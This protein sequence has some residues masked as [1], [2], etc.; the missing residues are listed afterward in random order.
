MFLSRRIHQKYYTPNTSGKTNTK[1]VLMQNKR[2][3]GRGVFLAYP[4]FNA[5]FE[6]HTNASKLQIGAVISQ[7]G[8]ASRFLLTKDEQRPTKLHHN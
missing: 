4:E 5:P 3:I 1:S 2:V 7:K 6:T 8:Q